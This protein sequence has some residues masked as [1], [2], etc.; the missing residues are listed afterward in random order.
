MDKFRGLRKEDVEISRVNNGS[1][2]LKEAERETL[3]QK[4]LSNFKDPIMV[5]LLIAL[6]INIVFAIMGKSEWIEPIGIA[7]AILLATGVGTISE[8]KNESSFRSLQDS[9]NANIVKVFRD[10]VLQEIHED[11]VVVG[12]YIQLR[13]GD[14]IPADGF[15]VDGELKVTQQ[16]LNG[17]SREETRIGFKTAS[18]ETNQLNLNNRHS[19][20]RGT[21]VSQGLAIMKVIKVG[22]KTI[23]GGINAGLVENEDRDTPLK[24]KLTSL[25]NFITKGAYI[26][27]GF[28]FTIHIIIDIVNKT[29]G[30]QSVVDGLMLAIVICV[31]SIPEGLPLMISLVSSINMKK[32]LKGNV[33]VRKLSGIETAGSLNIVFSDK[34]GTITKG[35]LEVVDAYNNCDKNTILNMQLNNETTY[36]GGDFV[37]GN[38]TD[39]AIMQYLV[40]EGMYQE[41]IKIE[42]KNRLPFNSTNKFSAI[43]IEVD[44]QPITFV[45]GAGE[46]IVARSEKK[47]DKT[48]LDTI[49]TWT[50]SAMRCLGFAMYEGTIEDMDNTFTLLNVIAIRDELRDDSREAIANAKK[51]GV[52]VVMITGDKLETARAIAKDAGLYESEDDIVL[53]ST[54]LESMTDEDIKE[55]L[56]KIRV[57]ARALP[58]DKARLVKV[59]QSMNLVAGMIGDE[60]NDSVA[61]KKS[62]VG[63]CMGSGSEVAKE[64]SDII[65]TDNSFNSIV[66]AILFGRTIFNNI[67]LFLLMQLTINVM[68]VGISAIFPLFGVEEPLTVVQL[69]WVN[70][71]MDTLASIAF[72]GQPALKKYLDEKPKKRDEDI[73]T[74]SMKKRVLIT[75]IGAIILSL[76]IVL[77]PMFNTDVK[78]TMLFDFVIFSA[79]ANAFTIKVSKGLEDKMFTAVMA[80]IVVVQVLMSLFGGPVLRTVMLNGIQWITLLGFVILMY[81]VSF[82][83]S[84]NK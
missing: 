29:F 69:L 23:F 3:L 30:V 7:I 73:L 72:G 1:N 36:S 78:L 71:V 79:V 2:K 60:V 8:W 20:F 25:A 82:I 65:I 75:G 77:L 59:A 13:M 52:Q 76:A 9:A 74:K 50:N 22:D 84:K 15:L 64:A 34:T 35:Q 62:D 28:V 24:V 53:T 44:K 10:N 51:A 41:D 26:I 31:A 47:D 83:S 33:L 57:I 49:D 17:E 80:L 32:M 67:K 61:L 70:I 27:A 55:C 40:S 19:V 37:G 54:D 42:I 38:A 43:E 12:D 46:V 14:K 68:A 16:A 39:K 45:K 58:A 5:I 81:V 56:S 63:F 11:D 18:I 6:C 4:W 21:Y 48:L 66:N